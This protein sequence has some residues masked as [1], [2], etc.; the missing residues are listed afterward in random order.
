[1]RSEYDRLATWREAL[2]AAALAACLSA[3]ADERER[4]MMKKCL[5]RYMVWGVAI[6]IL[7]LLGYSRQLFL[8]SAVR[9]LLKRGILYPR[10]PFTSTPQLTPPQS[11]GHLLHFLSQHHHCTSHHVRPDDQGTRTV[12]KDI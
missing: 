6:L 8:D 10:P 2:G 4:D 9:N 3:C 11:S 7:C 5:C 12:H 1:M